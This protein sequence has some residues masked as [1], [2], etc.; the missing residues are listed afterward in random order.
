[1]VFNSQL[2]PP[3]FELIYMDR[4]VVIIIIIHNLLY[5]YIYI[6]SRL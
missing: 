5:I 1:M 6:Y 4:Q 2:S 3:C